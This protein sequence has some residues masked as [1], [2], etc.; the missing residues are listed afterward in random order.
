MDPCPLAD[1][2]TAATR[3]QKNARREKIAILD[4]FALA[5]YGA[6]ELFNIF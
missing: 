4:F 2:R 6:T 3:M 1:S 5:Y